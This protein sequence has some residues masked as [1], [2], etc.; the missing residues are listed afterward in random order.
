MEISQESDNCNIYLVIPPGLEALAKLEFIEK[1]KLCFQSKHPKIIQSE[2]G[3]QFSVIFHEIEFLAL[4]LKIPTR[5]LLRVSDVFKVRD[6]PKLFTKIKKAI[7]IKDYLIK[8]PEII[9]CTTKQS[10]LLH[11]TKVEETIRKALN[12][13]FQH[14]PPKKKTTEYAKDYT[15]PVMHIR[16]ENDN[17]QISLDISGGNLYKR[18]DRLHIGEAP[19]RE[20]LAAAFIYFCQS[21]I[22]ESLCDPMCGSASLLLEA[23]SFYSP[24]SRN[25]LSFLTM[26]LFIKQKSSLKEIDVTINNNLREIN[27]KSY[28][29]D[30]C[31]KTLD[32]ARLN[33]KYSDFS[34][35]N[36]WDSWPIEATLDQIILNPPWNKRIKLDAKKNRSHKDLFE[37]LISKNSKSL[38]LI[39]PRDID[40]K[41]FSLQPKKK[42]YLTSGGINIQF[43]YWGS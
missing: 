8:T 41:K 2:G 33:N 7:W 21:H 23:H 9:K 1:W 24:I 18:G 15:S 16:I 17:C 4:H 31:L 38:G 34:E 29:L 37:L 36:I 26:P 6:F 22:Q 35:N 39:L 25:R 43:L 14:N 5:M 42:I 40:I 27:L 3:L 12:E 20:N 32:A 30:R 19:I 13:Y 28:G 10:R 11:S